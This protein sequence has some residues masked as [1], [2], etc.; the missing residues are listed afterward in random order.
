M[1]ARQWQLSLYYNN[2]GTIAQDQEL[3]D[4]CIEQQVLQLALKGD[5]DQ[6]YFADRLPNC[7]VRSTC[8]DSKFMLAYLL[9]NPVTVL[10]QFT[11]TLQHNSVKYQ[12][13]WVYVAINKYTVTTQQTWP[14]LTDDYDQDLLNIVATSL[15]DY[16]EIKRHSCL[17]QGQYFNFVHPTTYA[18]FKRG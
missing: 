18:Y 6:G 17:D 7:K 2:Q 1:N 3:I 10:E 13:A 14:N 9:P 12:P 8:F 11:K 4:F 15:P 5:P 16:T